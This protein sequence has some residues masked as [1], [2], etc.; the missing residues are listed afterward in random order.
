MLQKVVFLDRDGVI[1]RDSPDC[2]TSLGEFEFLPGSLEALQSLTSNGFSSIVVTNQSAL[3]AGRI[4]IET[5]QEIHEHM[6]AAVAAHGGTI[7][8]IFICP[9]RPEEGC[10]CRKP[11]PGLLFSAQRRHGIDLSSAVMVGDSARDIECAW[12]AGVP[13]TFLVKTGN[14]RQAARELAS[15]G[16]F[17]K[18]FVDDLRQAAERITGCLPAACR[19]APRPRS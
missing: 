11:K 4:S 13:A 16:L 2:I 1:N 9:H 17:P 19:R 5:L 10:A 8:D 15:K 7:L 6:C 18:F 12:N 3:H 14:G